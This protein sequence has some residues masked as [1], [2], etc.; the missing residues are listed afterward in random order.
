MK[1][2]V[3][4]ATPSVLQTGAH[5]SLRHDIGVRTLADVNVTLRLEKKCRGFRWPL[6][7]LKTY[8]GQYFRVT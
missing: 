7:R 1:L 2:I 4:R 8:P 5:R 6:H 3:E